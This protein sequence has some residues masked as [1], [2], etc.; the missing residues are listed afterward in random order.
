[1]APH[2]LEPILAPA[3]IALFGASERPGS[4]GHVVLARLLDGGFDG[5]L[6][7]IDP[8]QPEIQG[9]ASWPNLDAVGQ[10][11]DL[12]VIATPADGLADVLRQCGRHGVR[13]ALL[14]SG[15]FDR[16]SERGKALE[17]ELL[18]IARGFNLRLLGPDCLGIMHSGRHLNATFSN[19]H[20]L[21]GNIALVSQSGAIC[22]AVL[23][24]A[25][26]QQIGFSS[27]ISMGNAVD[28]GFGDV[29]DYLA[30][31]RKARSILLYVESIRDARRFMSGLR[32]AAR[33]KPVI[34]IKPGRHAESSRVAMSH[35]HS[36]VGADDVFA[37]ALERAGA[38]R[39]TTITQ[40][41]AAARVLSDGHLVRGNRLA[42]VTN[43]GGPGV[44]ATDHALEHDL[45][46]ASLSDKTLDALD[47]GLPEHGSR[48]NPVDL[49]EDAGPERF[50]TALEACLEDAGVDGVIA[51]LT[52]QV[53]SD[54]L[55]VA[56]VTAALAR[57]ARK[58]LLGCWM[59]DKQV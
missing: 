52:P 41:F 1:M 9:Q 11:V 16:S 31:D 35:T 19:N 15:G 25:A 55:G 10:P 48:G 59:G 57:N 17:R 53:N 29:L 26:G 33:M 50:K 36:L 23:D 39:A 46:L 28:V 12:A 54:P 44:M 2:F 58:P 47:A 4:K 8:Q 40:L 13:G 51:M 3:S 5:A 21:P 6:F 14:L 27:V 42:I 22:T 45:V 49:H 32:A 37:A 24:W 7:I 20:A 43:A 30:L 56:R 18:E 38:V 34:V